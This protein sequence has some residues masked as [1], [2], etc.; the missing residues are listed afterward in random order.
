MLVGSNSTA[1]RA[2]LW[3]PWEDGLVKC[4]QRAKWVL[5]TDTQSCLLL[6]SIQRKYFQFALKIQC[7]LFYRCKQVI[8]LMHKTNAAKWADDC[9]LLVQT[10]SKVISACW[11]AENHGRNWGPTNACWPCE[12]K[13]LRHFKICFSLFSRSTY[14]CNYFATPS[15]R[16]K[17]C[18]Y[19]R[20]ENYWSRTQTPKQLLFQLFL[21]LFLP[22]TWKLS[23][24]PRDLMQV[25]ASAIAVLQDYKVSSL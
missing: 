16:Q 11:I 6:E 25:S 9:I 21:N 22:Q 12:N 7:T 8:R 19:Y 24:L 4:N 23:A 15:G 2:A 17:S 1:S 18:L 14:N 5:R 3:P 13:S 10:Q 20:A